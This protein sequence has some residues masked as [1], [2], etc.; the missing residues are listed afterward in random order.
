MN[1]HGDVFIRPFQD[2]ADARLDSLLSMYREY[3]VRCQK[4]ENSEHAGR[5]YMGIIVITQ[6]PI[7]KKSRFTCCQSPFR[8]LYCIL[9]QLV[10]FNRIQDN[11]L[12]KIKINKQ[13]C[14]QHV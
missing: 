3:K 1:Q 11:C 5:P 9:S 7:I 4:K 2:F 6:H 12:K 14:N 8:E 13:G 10:S